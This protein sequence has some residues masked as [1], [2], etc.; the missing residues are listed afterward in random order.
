L[1]APLAKMGCSQGD[2]VTLCQKSTTGLYYER[3]FESRTL[4]GIKRK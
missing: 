3:Y 2:S 4:L 1:P